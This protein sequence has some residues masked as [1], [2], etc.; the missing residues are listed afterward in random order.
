MKTQKL[1]FTIEGQWLTHFCRRR[2]ADEDE[3]FHAIQVLE[4]GFPMFGLGTIM[5][6]LTGKKQLVGDSTKGVLLQDD[7]A[8]KSDLGNELSFAAVMKKTI[9]RAIKDQVDKKMEPVYRRFMHAIE[10]T[11]EAIE[12]CDRNMLNR[13]QKRASV[14]AAKAAAYQTDELL[15][16]AS[17]MRYGDRNAQI[18]FQ[19]WES[20]GAEL[21]G[22]PGPLKGN[23]CG[24]LRP[25]GT[26]YPC[27]Y[28]QHDAL[29][30][31]LKAKNGDE[32]LQKGWV[33]IQEKTQG[34]IKK[35]ADFYWMKKPT[36]AQIDKLWDWCQANNREFPKEQFD[37]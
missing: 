18:M 5:S 7:T 20:M 32:L 26:F 25:D 35:P 1:H 17:L 31:A 8:T 30:V 21:K 3:P 37:E 33:K 11:E 4:S 24:W 2:W 9:D 29:S 15:D 28:F 27:A 22:E 6:I 36:Q 14:D 10:E 13:I 16:R 23:L 12:S 34:L 19:Y